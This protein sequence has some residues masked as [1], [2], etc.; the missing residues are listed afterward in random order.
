MPFTDC[1]KHWNLWSNCQNIREKEIADK[2]DKIEKDLRRKRII[3][4]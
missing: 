3:E 4:E 1:K 2:Y